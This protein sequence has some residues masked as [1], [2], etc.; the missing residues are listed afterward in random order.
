[1]LD[2]SLKNVKVASSSKEDSIIHFEMDFAEELPQI[3]VDSAQIQQVLLNIYLNAVDAIEAEGTITTITT[4]TRM[5]DPETIWIEISDTGKGMSEQSLLKIFN[6]FFTTK[7]KGTGLG[8]SISKRLMDQHCGNIEV[9]SCEGS[10]TSFII[11]L[12]L[13]HKYQE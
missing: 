13:T 2:N 1:L 12:P 4:I 5:A 8:L 11:T 7:T 6:P 3:E 9:H 10:G